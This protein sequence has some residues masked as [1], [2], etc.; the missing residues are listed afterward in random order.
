META[1]RWSPSSDVSEQ[2]FLL[3]DV[4]ARSFNL[5]KVT[6]YD[7]KSLKH[8]LLPTYRKV[9]AFRAFDWAPFEES[10]VAVGQWS[11]EA[12]VLR[13]DDSAAPISL[14]TKHQRLCNAVSF[15]RTGLL[16][17]GLERVR[18]VE[19]LNLWDVSQR[20]S[21]VP[22][23]GGRSGKSV[24]PYRKYSSSE[25]ISSIKFLAR[26]PEILVAG[27]KGVG[28]RIYDLRENT[29]NASLQFQTARVHNIAIDYV[30]ENYFACAGTGK[31]TTIQ[32]WDCRSGSPYTASGT[33]AAAD[34]SNQTSPVVEIAE[35]FATAKNASQANIWSLRYCKGKSG[36][37]GALASNGEFK[38]FETSH[39][40]SRA[41]SNNGSQP[42]S[43]PFSEHLLTKRIH[44]IERAYDDL[45]EPRQESERIVAFDFTNLAGSKGTP[46]AI[47]LRGNA[48]IS[49]QELS[50]PPTAFALS[51]LGTLIVS[52]SHQPVSDSHDNSND[53][54]VRT[55]NPNS[56]EPVAALLED[57]GRTLGLSTQ[58]LGRTSVSNLGTLREGLY[59]SREAHE[60]AVG[61]RA[62][63]QTLKMED[64][65]ALTT[66]TRRRCEDGY[67]LNVE[68]NTEILGINKW[69]QLM[70]TWIERAQNNAKDNGMIAGGLDLSYLGVSDIWHSDMSSEQV[71]RRLATSNAETDF[72]DSV[73]ALAQSLDLPRFASA[74]T[75]S[76]EH[77]QIC[78]YTCGLGLSSQQVEDTVKELIGDGEKTKAA[79]LAIIHDSPK[80]ALQALRAGDTSAVQRELSLALAGYVKGTSDDTWHE[81]IQELAADLED[82]Y[83][84]AILAL[85]SHGSWHDVLKETSLPLRDRIGIALMYLSDDELT[86]YINTTTAEA[87]KA[88]D[89]EGIV[90][91]G[92][93]PK[94][95]PLFETYISKF[96]D[97]QTAVLALAFAFP[98]YFTDPRVT[99]WR[100]TYRSHLDKFGMFLHRAQ[101]DVQSSK[102][103]ATPSGKSTLPPAPR[104][105]SLRCTYCDQNLDRNSNHGPVGSSGASHGTH[106]GSIFGI[107]AKSGTVC[108]KCGRHMPRCGI[109]MNWVGMPDAHTKGGL[110]KKMEKGEAMEN[111]VSVC[112]GC[113]HVSHAGHAEEWFRRHSV[114]AVSGCE[115]RCVEVDAG[116]A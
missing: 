94:S 52:K 114:C 69:L 15:N 37:L 107:A 95:I 23:P 88:G 1:I 13:I 28:I 65:L 38:V 102:I 66:V 29:G 44:G 16:A 35:A 8:N 51:A 10:L 61:L 106:Q 110:A 99:A 32:M 26:Q 59:S 77:R 91:T 87:I 92:L 20:L 39:G 31:D 3:A 105:I 115:C 70:W 82:P 100:Q 96:S 30:N 98:R 25:A 50:G 41:D 60:R 68:K 79:A 103:S 27:V 72:A 78:L 81:T 55:Y 97:L 4:T 45:H 73:I 47:I 64:A 18:N 104:Q 90:L 19:C 17:T 75:D 113:W 56:D 2:Q 22:S 93:S 109:C 63:I 24:E 42:A 11:G 116:V 112:H 111:F 57:I 48:S 83:A 36:I 34:Q 49:I 89:I 53:E 7:G 12:T 6:Q 80:L 5:A 84:R 40:Y 71:L 62:G 108:P 43:S 74:K 58:Q 21:P 54:T 86:Q 46:S 101:F 33:G 67:A 85:V 76:P 9:P 14:P